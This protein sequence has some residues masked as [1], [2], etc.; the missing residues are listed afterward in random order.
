MADIFLSYARADKA[1]I[2]ALV[3]R[4]LQEKWSVFWDPDILPGHQWDEHLQQELEAARVV[5][6]AWST[7]SIASHWVRE[8][9]ASGRE[10]GVLVPVVID[11]TKL[12]FGFALIQAE[13][14]TDW[15]G[16]SDTPA[17]T[18]LLHG[19]RRILS[20]GA[21]PAAEAPVRAVEPSSGNR[22]EAI[23]LSSQELIERL[24]RP[25]YWGEAEGGEARR[26]FQSLADLRK[27]SSTE[28]LA[29]LK[30]LY[31]P[32][33][34]DALVTRAGKEPS[35]LKPRVSQFM[36]AAGEMLIRA[37]YNQLSFEDLAGILARRSPYGLDFI[38]DLEDFEEIGFYFRGNVTASDKHRS[39]KTLFFARTVEIPLFQRI[40]LVFKLAP[41]R[42]TLPGSSSEFVYIRLFK[43]TP[44]ADI[45]ILFPN[46]SIR[47]RLF[48]KL[49]AGFIAAAG[50]GLEFWAR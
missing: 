7:S 17:V 47:V 2:E 19:V 26:F 31:H 8:E 12:P 29:D 6:V 27:A 30:V 39:W 25:L 33:D 40:I 1:R 14:L 48:D 44:R 10:R 3:S 36:V 11:N 32:L 50:V 5:V 4:L 9:A 20:D 42:P 24:T 45:A 38:V 34:P 41:G 37:G 46:T 28:A 43:D 23:P 13:R 22:R 16:R 35:E 15:D 18:R 21:A 49:R